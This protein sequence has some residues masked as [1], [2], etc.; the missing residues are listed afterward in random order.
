MAEAITEV[1]QP[2][3]R[4]IVLI[5]HSGGGTLAVLL[6]PRIEDVSGVVSI[7]ANLDIDAWAD[8]HNYDRLTGSLNPNS[9]PT[10]SA[11]PHEQ[12]AGLRDHDLEEVVMVGR[13][14]SDR[15]VWQ[16]IW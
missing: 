4:S 12:M 3:H 11:I 15:M 6:A 16:A 2:R 7:A 10:D 8:H 5:G 9:Q 1:R 14:S 13:T